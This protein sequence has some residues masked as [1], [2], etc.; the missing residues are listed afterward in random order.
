MQPPLSI[1][2]LMSLPGACLKAPQIGLKPVITLTMNFIYPAEL[3]IKLALLL[4]YVL[5]CIAAMSLGYIWGALSHAF[6]SIEIPFENY[7][8]I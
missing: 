3:I 6:N 8:N 7:L 2:R 4:L 5:T 1:F